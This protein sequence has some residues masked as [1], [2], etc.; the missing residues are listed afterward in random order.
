MNREMKATVLVDNCTVDHYLGSE[1]GLSVHFET[2][3][4][5]F[6]LDTGTSDLLITN[7]IQLGVD[8]MAVD[9]VFISHGHADHLG[10]LIAFLQINTQA[11]VIISR[12]ALEQTFYSKKRELHNISVD[13]DLSSYYHR[14][15]FV[16]DHLQLNTYVTVFAIENHN[17]SLPKGNQFLYKE[18]DGVCIPDNFDHELAILFDQN[19]TTVFTGCA[20][21]GIVNILE[22]A[23]SYSKNQ[24]NLVLGGFHLI[25]SSSGEPLESDSELAAL[26]NY[27][28]IHY[29]NTHFL[30]GHCTAQKPFEKLKSIM[31][32]QLIQFYSGFTQLT[33]NIK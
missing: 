27:L 33:N 1:H 24:I 23:K 11:K 17:Y 10:G 5:N 26:A 15:L 21:N 2:D 31:G 16:D 32:N 29:P 4:G 20:H 8:L 30:T 25:E 12:K 7:A 14:F 28:H 9:Y 3:F 22:T 13:V 6:L 19:S 18:I